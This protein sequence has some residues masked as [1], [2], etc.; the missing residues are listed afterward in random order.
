MAG[1]LRKPAKK[2]VLSGCVMDLFST[3]R[4]ITCNNCTSMKLIVETGSC[5]SIKATSFLKI[6]VS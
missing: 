2:I 1:V 4:S 3:R 5:K 6:L